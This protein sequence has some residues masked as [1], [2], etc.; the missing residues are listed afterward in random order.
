MAE[1]TDVQRGKRRR[2]RSRR[3]WNRRKQRK[4]KQ[5]R[6]GGGGGGRTQRRTR[7]YVSPRATNGTRA[8]EP[9][10]SAKA[11]EKYCIKVGRRWGLDFV[12]SPVS[13]ARDA[14][15]SQ[16]RATPINQRH[17]AECL[18]RARDAE[19][20]PLSFFPPIEE[21]I[22]GNEVKNRDTLRQKY[23]QLTRRI[24]KPPTTRFVPLN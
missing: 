1:E 9:A 10:E 18:G 6:G 16:R 19:N 8:R 22:G 14:P 4:K 13:F 2:G 7:L 20:P 24:R 15:H 12:Y 5:R 21:N 17:A 23:T 11:L 3:E